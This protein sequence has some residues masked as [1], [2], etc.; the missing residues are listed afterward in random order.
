MGNIVLHKTKYMRKLFV[1]VQFI[2]ATSF[3]LIAA[4]VE[5]ALQDDLTYITEAGYPNQNN[6]VMMIQ[7]PINIEFYKF[8]VNL[9]EDVK[10]NQKKTY[11]Y[12]AL[13]SLFSPINPVPY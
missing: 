12:V 5:K 2:L 6:T 7:S 8:A 9:T 3:M 10:R 13:F 11:V 4:N 1:L